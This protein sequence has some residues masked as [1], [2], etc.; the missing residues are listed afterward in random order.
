MLPKI[1]NFIQQYFYVIFVL[2]TIIT[3]V[4]GKIWS[5]MKKAHAE[6]NRKDREA[7]MRLDEL[8]TGKAQPVSQGAMMHS[9]QPVAMPQTVSEKRSLQDIAAERERRLAANRSQ[10]PIA[11]S[12][13]PLPTAKPGTRLIR[14]P[15][16]I[17]IEVPDET[18]QQRSRPQQHTPASRPAPKAAPKPVQQPARAKPRKQTPK[19]QPTHVEQPLASRPP[20]DHSNPFDTG[21]STTHRLVPDTTSTIEESRIRSTRAKVAATGVNL[22]FLKNPDR[23]EL[24]RAFIM[25]EVLGQP[26]GVA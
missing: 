17:V 2:L 23:A 11:T 13:A 9:P 20:H 26:K 4:L 6:K 3:P 5:N 24:K 12:S 8:R 16:G 1:L 25:S 7:Q 19:Q 22:A 15:G 10:N 18:A 21:E 14:L